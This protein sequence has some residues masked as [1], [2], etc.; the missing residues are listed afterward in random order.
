MSTCIGMRA[1][2]CVCVNLFAAF[3]GAL[4]INS[5]HISTIYSLF[6]VTVRRC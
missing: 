2:V 4:R 1:G 3:M 6:C 5:G